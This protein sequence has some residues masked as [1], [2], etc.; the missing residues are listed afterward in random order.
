MQNCET[1]WDFISPRLP[2]THTD[3]THRP[4]RKPSRMVLRPAHGRF[5]STETPPT[6]VLSSTALPRHLSIIQSPYEKMPGVSETALFLTTMRMG[7]RTCPWAHRRP[8]GLKNFS[9]SMPRVQIDVIP[10]QPN[11][12]LSIWSHLDVMTRKGADLPIV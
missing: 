6:D 1:H 4:I 2:P 3:R 5:R 11:K 8:H 10:C 7:C 12:D 9:I